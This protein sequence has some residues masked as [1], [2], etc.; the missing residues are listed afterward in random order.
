LLRANVP[1]AIA[2][3]LVTNPLTY[4]PIYYV[5]WKLG[6]RVLGREGGSPPVLPTTTAAEAEKAAEGSL[7]RAMAGG[8]H[9]VGQPLALGLA[10]MACSLGLFT[11]FAISWGW[12][13]KVNLSR[14]RRQRRQRRLRRERLAAAAGPHTHKG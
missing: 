11:Y 7:S 8:L 14:L 12:V 4:A 5:A 10:L 6:S 9:G 13:L 1:A 3:T 2:S